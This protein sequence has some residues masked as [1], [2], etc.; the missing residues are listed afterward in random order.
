MTTV[1]DPADY[2]IKPQE[3]EQ[4]IQGVPGGLER[5]VDA[6]SA[7][8][9][10]DCEYV[11]N[12]HTESA[13]SVLQDFADSLSRIGAHLGVR[14]S[15]GGLVLGPEHAKTLAD[16]GYSRADVQQWLFEHATHTEAE[17]AAAGKGGGAPAA[18]GV[19]AMMPSAAESP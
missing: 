11:D 4:A 15:S 19:V 17:L 10:R 18:D 7:M 9:I 13:E 3:L 5:G 16:A 14:H 2:G 6:V 8:L 12:R 1:T